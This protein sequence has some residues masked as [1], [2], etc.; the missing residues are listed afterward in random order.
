MCEVCVYV[1]LFGRSP[2]GTFPPGVFLF[3]FKDPPLPLSFPPEVIV[4]RKK[5]YG[6]YL[7]MYS[8]T[9]KYMHVYA[10]MY[11]YTKKNMHVIDYACMYC[12]V[13]HAL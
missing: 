5:H 11:S 8:H 4:F 9:K 13:T 2:P 6:M 12:M 3:I 7:C 10:C 1:V